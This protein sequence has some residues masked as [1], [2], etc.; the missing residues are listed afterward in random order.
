MTLL[1]S[2]IWR[3]MSIHHQTLWNEAVVRISY[4]RSFD[5]VYC[6]FRAGVEACP[7]NF[8]FSY[9]IRGV[10]ASR[11]ERTHRERFGDQR[12]QRA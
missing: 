9:Q 5:S 11:R 2:C 8:M 3:L 7:Y 10:P 1:G 4:L 6:I 12:S